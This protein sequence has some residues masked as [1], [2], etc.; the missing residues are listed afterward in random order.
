MKSDVSEKWQR[1]RTTPQERAAWVRRFERSGL[2][3]QEFVTRHRLVLSTLGRWRADETQVAA[4]TSLPLH[5]VK[6]SPMLGP[7]PWLAEV[8]R[9]DGLTIRLSA[10]A[11]PLVETLL[12][13]RPC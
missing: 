10:A 9:P 13:A 6:L 2:T 8:Q 3:R 12:T 5:E 4:G 1:H 7:S 11:R